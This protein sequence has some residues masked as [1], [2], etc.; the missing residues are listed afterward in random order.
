MTTRSNRAMRNRRGNRAN[1]AGAAAVEM[2]FVIPV[3]FILVFGSIELC[4]RVYTK[5]SAVIAA[6]E[7]CRVATRQ[8]SDTA[9]VE[10]ACQT[11][12]EEQGVEG[13]SIQVRD[14][15]RGQNHLDDIETGDEIRVRITVPWGDNIISQYIVKNQGNFQVNAHMLRE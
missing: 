13:A 11:L 2:A 14:M 15:E 10:S 12:L 7:A 9:A 3:L 4:Q 1:R 6:Y 5:Q 8:T